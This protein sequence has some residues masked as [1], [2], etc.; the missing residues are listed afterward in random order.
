MPAL[1]RGSVD[2]PGPSWR[3]RWSDEN[4]R[5]RER[6]GFRTKTE[7]RTWLRVEV[8]AVN[9]RRLSREIP[10]HVPAAPKRRKFAEQDVTE[11]ARS[12][13]AKGGEQ[14]SSAPHE[15]PRRII[16]PLVR[17]REVAALLGVSTRWVYEESQ[18]YDR[19]DPRGL[20]SYRF[21][22]GKRM[23]IRFDRRDVESWLERHRSRESLPAA[24]TTP[25]DAGGICGDLADDPLSAM[26]GP[27]AG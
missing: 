18:A 24:A 14:A 8:D 1:Q 20:P 12:S 23:S 15:S 19:G 26:V 22:S 5:R 16:G 11:I 9:R 6:R 3:A 7:A 13:T 4:G 25:S 17:V 27:A 10:N 2:K 21:G